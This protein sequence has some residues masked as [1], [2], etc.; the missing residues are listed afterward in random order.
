MWY[1]RTD[2]SA[3]QLVNIDLKKKKKDSCLSEPIC[4]LVFITMTTYVTG[5]IT[6]FVPITELS[7]VRI[8]SVLFTIQRAKG[9]VDVRGEGR[10]A[11]V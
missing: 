9:G 4:Q 1:G 5:S 7:S 2:F 11:S 6:I 10:I 8:D 3:S